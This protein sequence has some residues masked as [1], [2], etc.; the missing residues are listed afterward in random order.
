MPLYLK[1]LSSAPD[2]MFV[3]FDDQRV[4]DA[5][6]DTV[7]SN[8]VH[9]DVDKH[10]ESENQGICKVDGHMHYGAVSMLEGPRFGEI[11]VVVSFLLLQ[12]RPVL[13]CLRI[14]VQQKVV[15]VL[16]ISSQTTRNHT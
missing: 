3:L 16:R 8:F 1:N 15:R 14:E 4:F 5:I 9:F 10:L 6:E 12:I 2:R 11:V 13:I 7:W